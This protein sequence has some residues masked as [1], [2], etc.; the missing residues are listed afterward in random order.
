MAHGGARWRTARTHARSAITAPDTP[1]RVV[2]VTSAPAS[3][4]LDMVIAVVI[5]SAVARVVVRAQVRAVGVDASLR[6]AYGGTSTALQ[7]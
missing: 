4:S 6:R 3:A 5:V 7:S 1:M 2:V